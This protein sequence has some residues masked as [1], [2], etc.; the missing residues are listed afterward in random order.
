MPKNSDLFNQVWAPKYETSINCKGYGVERGARALT[1]AASDSKVVGTIDEKEALTKLVMAGPAGM[2]RLAFAMQQPLKDRLDYVAVGRKL[3]LVDE[4]PQ[5]EVPQ[6]D[7]DQPEFGAVKIG[8]RGKPPIVEMNIKRVEFPT[9]KIAVNDTVD[10]EEIQIRRYPAFDRAKE[11]TAIANAIAED[12]E[13]F[14]L[15]KKASTVGPNTPLGPITSAPTR[16]DFVDMY[17]QMTS[18]QLSPGTYLMHPVR[19]GDI[20]RWK[21]DELDQVSLNV[22]IET[23]QYGVLHG[24]RLL[25]STR[26][27][28]TEV[29]L[30]TTP[31]KLGRLPERKP[32]ELKVWDYVPQT[33]YYV[34]S[35]EQIGMGIH[36]T[37]G[38]T[39]MDVNISG[40][41]D[42]YQYPLS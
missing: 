21:P 23:G 11:R 5:G 39:R 7:L 4:L 17:V 18:R 40:D 10:Y 3:L 6:Y 9:F 16:G 8:A 15:L 41:S 25:A 12:N 38:V 37:A 1:R 13:I 36:N 19:L 42:L 28:P 26:V 14:A 30:T 20:M 31:D 33:K 34:L 2:Q 27:N 35:W 22:I 24:V 29:Y 32:V